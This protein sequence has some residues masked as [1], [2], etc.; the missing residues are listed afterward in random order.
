MIVWPLLS[1]NLVDLNERMNKTNDAHCVRVSIFSE[2][3]AASAGA[4]WLD[5]SRREVV[6]DEA[7]GDGGLEEDGGGY[8]EMYIG[9]RAAME[10]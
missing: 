8:C 6:G 1:K 3:G 9:G 5:E 2:D 7:G 4:V 10:G